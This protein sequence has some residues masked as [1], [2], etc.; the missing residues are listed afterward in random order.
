MKNWQNNVPGE[1]WASFGKVVFGVWFL[2][3]VFAALHDQYLIRIYP[4][5]FTLWHYQIPWIKDYTLLAIAYAFGASVTPGLML[6]VV[7][8]GVSRLSRRPKI[9]NRTIF[10]GVF[11][12]FLGVELCAIAAG[13][14]AWRT[15]REIYPEWLYPDIAPGIIITQSIQITAYLSGMILSLGL[16]VWLWMKRGRVADLASLS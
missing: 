12:V 9:S 2:V 8:Y 14:I 13:L 11:L 10:L 5:H 15:G 6:G 4:E 7:L 1:S 16:I 3:W